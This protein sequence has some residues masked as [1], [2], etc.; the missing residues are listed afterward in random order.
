M[1]EAAI[2]RCGI[3]DLLLVYVWALLGSRSNQTS[4]AAAPDRYK[5]PRFSHG[6]W[7]FRI[8][9]FRPDFQPA[10]DRVGQAERV[11]MMS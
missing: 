7:S 3:A 9:R 4:L 11:A 10:E 1:R 5:H 8:G 6:T 2:N